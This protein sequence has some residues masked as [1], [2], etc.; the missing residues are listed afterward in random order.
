MISAYLALVIITHIDSVFLPGNEI[1]IPGPVANAIPG[2]DAKGDSGPKDRI[3]ILVMGLD[4]RE[5][6]GDTPTRTDTIFIVTVDPKTKSTSILGIPRDLW[7]N[8]PY[9]DGSGTFEDRINTVYV[10]G[11]TSKYPQG[12]VG[13]MKDVLKSEPFDIKIDHYVM[14]DFKGFESLIDDLGGIDVDVPEE[15]VDPYYSETELPGDYLPQHFYPGL[16][17]MDGETAL[18]YSRIRFDSDDLDRI[19]RQQRVI[20]AAVD[21]ANSV[22]ALKN[23]SSLWDRYKSTV[24]TDISD[25][26]IPGYAALGLQVKD[27]INA[28]SIGSATTPYIT[29]EGASV[30]I[31][32]D[33]KIKQIVQSLF[34]D[35]V[36]GTGSV[37][38]EATTTPEPV[39][40]QVQNGAGTEG[41]AASVMGY[42]IRRGYP[43]GDVNATNVFDGQAHATSE[44]LD[45]DGTHLRN[46]YLLANWLNIPTAQVRT[47]TAEEQ[48]AL[49]GD[50]ADIVIVLGSDVDYESVIQQPA[51]SVAGG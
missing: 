17:H 42:L 35:K 8:I 43:Q 38:A 6:E 33:E 21:K 29:R 40:V 2:V 28:V 39:A 12:G 47:A 15:V 41:L 51:T 9:K 31:G 14:I 26:Q 44:I 50:T 20:F 32:D 18:A 48:A 25:F 11:E 37:Q 5:R 23:A 16:Q 49:A 3:N 7:V 4:R 30:L 10:W 19:Q 45:L 24:K 13:L 1:T 34:V 22:D 36:G 27:D 46:A